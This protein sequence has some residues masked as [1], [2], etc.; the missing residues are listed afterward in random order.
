MKLDTERSIEISLWQE[1]TSKETRKV[2]QEVL[3]T[4]QRTRHRISLWIGRVPLQYKL[5]IPHRVRG[6]ILSFNPVRKDS[7][8]RATGVMGVIFLREVLM[9]LMF[10]IRQHSTTSNASIQGEPGAERS[11]EN[12]SMRCQGSD[13]ITANLFTRL[14]VP[15][16]LVPPKTSSLPSRNFLASD[17][18]A[19]FNEP[20]MFLQLFR[21][22]I[23]PLFSD[24]CLCISCGA[25]FAC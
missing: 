20:R 14:A 22:T 24:Q 17:L 13:D 2:E 21:T 3:V 5:V 16:S 7:L 25:R 11:S 1:R 9:S 4:S 19:D 15:P 10:K 18:V 12:V 8:T 6:I 23:R